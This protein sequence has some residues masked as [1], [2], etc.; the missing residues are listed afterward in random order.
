[1]GIGPR[2]ETSADYYLIGDA[3]HDEGGCNTFSKQDADRFVAQSKGRWHI[4][5]IRKVPLVSVNRVME[6]NFGGAPDFLSTDTEGLDFDILRSLDFDRFR[7]AIV[8]AEVL[9][10]AGRVESRIPE[11]MT[12]KGYSMRGSTWVNAIFV[13]D[14]RGTS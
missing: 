3:D 10:A 2:E 13:D 4:M 11:L 9:V 5:E 7:P 8:C 14:R 1:M 12:S 6:E